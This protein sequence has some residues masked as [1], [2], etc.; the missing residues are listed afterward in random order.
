MYYQLQS[1]IFGE[2]VPEIAEELDEDISFTSGTVIEK[3]LPS[4]LVFKTDHSTQVQ[5]RGMEGGLFPLMSDSFIAAL[6]KA[7]VSNLQCFPVEL[8]S[9]IDQTIW[10]NYK[11]VNVIG[12]NSCVDQN[13]SESTHIIDRPTENAVP[14]TFFEKLKID[15]TLAAG[16]LLFRL[17]ESPS[18]LIVAGSVVKYLHSQKSDDEWGITLDEI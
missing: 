13:N 1:D 5:P 12:L 7:G 14:L 8:I 2:Y 4:P 16:K 17:A 18:T 6:E 10:K 15:P 9:N 11:A 3:L